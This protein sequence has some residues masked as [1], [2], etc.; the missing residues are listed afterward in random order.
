MLIPLRWW[1]ILHFNNEDAFKKL[2]MNMITFYW[3]HHSLSHA[4]CWSTF[5]KNTSVEV[6]RTWNCYWEN[7]K[8]RALKKERERRSEV[9]KNC[10]LILFYTKHLLLYFSLFINFPTHT[11]N[12]INTN[13]IKNAKNITKK[14][15]V[16][17]QNP[18]RKS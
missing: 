9:P 17:K 12:Y 10:F 14:H 18:S 5:K 3:Q 2:A 1:M 4:H 16:C 6:V 7:E 8:Y 13:P 15:S 11:K